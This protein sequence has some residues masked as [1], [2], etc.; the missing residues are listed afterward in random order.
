MLAVL[1]IYRP[2]QEASQFGRIF[3][4]GILMVQFDR[5]IISLIKNYQN[6]VEK[7]HQL[8]MTYSPSLLAP[9]WAE[10]SIFM[11]LHLL[12]IKLSLGDHINQMP[13]SHE[14]LK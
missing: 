12:V 9:N 10:V 4:D 14:T 13:I 5:Y 2:S 8:M 1:S 11:L 7:S 3:S 6:T